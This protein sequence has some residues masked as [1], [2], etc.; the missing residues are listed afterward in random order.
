MGGKQSP[1]GPNLFDVKSVKVPNI[2]NNCCTFPSMYI[3][4]QTE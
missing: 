2:P 3:L 4:I 1:I